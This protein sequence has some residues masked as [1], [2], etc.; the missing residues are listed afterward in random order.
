MFGAEAAATHSLTPAERR[1]VE[2]YPERGRTGARLRAEVASLLDRHLANGR[3]P[4]VQSQLCSGVVDE[5]M[6]GALLGLHANNTM[7]TRELAPLPTEMERA[8]IAWLLR[9]VPWDAAGA[10]GSATPGGSY[11]NYL[12]IY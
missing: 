4:R 9:H 7:S 8:V 1:L 10:G 6:A 11:S 5:A 2:A 12:G 3:S